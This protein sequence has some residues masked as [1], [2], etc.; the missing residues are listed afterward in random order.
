ME[1]EFV[2]R[3][4]KLKTVKARQAREEIAGTTPSKMSEADKQRLRRHYS[5]KK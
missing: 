4:E 2:D 1:G 5:R 3:V